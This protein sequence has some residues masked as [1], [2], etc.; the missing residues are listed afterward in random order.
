MFP[1]RQNVPPPLGTL[2]YCALLTIT[3]AIVLFLSW[4]TGT[5]HLVHFSYSQWQNQTQ[6]QS[7]P[8]PSQPPP[9]HQQQQP[10]GIPKKI[11]YK[12]GPSGLTN[13]T[14][15]WTSTCLNANPTYTA[16]Y[17]T[18]A[19][20]ATYVQSAWASRPDILAAYLNLTVPI[21]KADL[22]RYMLLYEQGGVWFD[23]DV[24]CEGVPIDEWVPAEFRT[25]DVGV[26]L[27]WE[28]DKGWEGKFVRQF[29][30]WTIVARRGSP[31]MLQVVEDV[32][33][34]LGDVV[35]VR[36]LSSVAEVELGMV[37][38]VVDFSG[39][40][41]LTRGVLKSL[42]R[43]LNREVEAGE[44]SE[45]LEPR[46]VGDVLVLPGRSFA[47]SANRYGAEEEGRLPPK[48][49]EHHYAGSW[50]NEQGGEVV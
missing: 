1:L 10:Q 38:D 3:G 28:F 35:L 5:P 26:V 8:Q 48:L 14:R 33:E 42:G 24:S 32:V 43:E 17:L 11:W 18:D 20:A 22:L 6:S 13:S 25:K 4:P 9:D 2:L 12:L 39:P 36:N 23:L 29:A 44:I 47:E 40:R 46:L 41:R 7:Q 15:V 50:K 31:H 30:S 27:G 34:A 37:G 49:V 21:L 45:L 16:K 19:S